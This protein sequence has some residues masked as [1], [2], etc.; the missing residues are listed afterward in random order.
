MTF[1]FSS[2]FL[3]RLRF[4]LIVVVCF[5]IKIYVG[6]GFEKFLVEQNDETKEVLHHRENPIDVDGHGF[7]SIS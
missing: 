6:V 3:L 7:P 1:Q 5:T 2:F 4:V